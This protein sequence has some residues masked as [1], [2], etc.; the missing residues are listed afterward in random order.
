MSGLYVT[1]VLRNAGREQGSI[2][3]RSRCGTELGALHAGLVQHES[4]R[5]ESLKPKQSEAV[6]PQAVLSPDTKG[7]GAVGLE[8]LVTNLTANDKRMEA[9][10]PGKEHPTVR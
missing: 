2:H 6:V 8:E 1:L 10:G 5:L 3:T 4:A 9:Q 7:H